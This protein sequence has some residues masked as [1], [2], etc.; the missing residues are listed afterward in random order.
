MDRLWFF[1]LGKL[2]LWNWRTHHPHEINNVVQIDLKRHC[3]RL[4][5]VSLIKFNLRYEV[6]KLAINENTI[7]HHIRDRNKLEKDAKQCASNTKMPSHISLYDLLIPSC[8][9]QILPSPFPLSNL[10][11]GQ[12]QTKPADQAQ[13]PILH[14]KHPE[15]FGWVYLKRGRFRVIWCPWATRMTKYLSSE[16]KGPKDRVTSSPATHVSYP[17]N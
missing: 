15:G 6:N 3:L 13:G 11:K 2:K 4:R 9:C 17:Q 8:W 16:N 5:N 14:Q 7:T 1:K 12:K 10:R